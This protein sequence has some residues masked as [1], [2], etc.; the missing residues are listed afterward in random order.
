VKR[1]DPA[2]PPVDLS[3]EAVQNEVNR[4]LAS[5]KFARSKR[6]R[7]LL[8]FTV[9]QTLQGNADS[10][11]EYVI[12]TEV[13]NKPETYDPRRDS[14]V[15][16]LA[17]RLRLKLKEYYNDGGSEDPLV[18]EFPKG[19][20]VP[21]FQRREHLQ[22]ETEKKLKARNAYSRGKFLLLKLT[23]EALRESAGEFNDAAAADPSW[24]APQVGLATAY[25]LLGFLGFERPREVWPQ[26]ITAAE[27]ALRLDEM[28]SEPHI[29]LGMA[30]AFYD[31]RWR[32][33]DSHFMKAVERDPYSGA[34]PVWR[35][36]ASLL[37]MG[38]VAGARVEIERGRDLAPAPF[39]KEAEVLALY[40]AE[41]YE[42]VLQRTEDVAHV[43]PSL[44]WLP[45]LRSAALAASG[46]GDAA[47]NSLE[48]L[49]EKFPGSSRVAATLGQVYG[50][51]GR[52]AQANEVLAQMKRRREGGAWVP[53]FDFAVVHA[54]MGSPDEAFEALQESVKEKET[55]LVYLTVD[56]RLS[57]LRHSPKFA[58][59]VRRVVLT[60]IEGSSLAVE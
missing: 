16:V 51:A 40:F 38:R 35:A 28:S 31:W 1:Y 34:G 53:N 12:G 59:L 56:P 58:Q 15:R 32:D 13:L 6:L 41:Q 29:A 23:E 10:L 49:L 37:P 30:R 17:S 4:I 22:A 33:A 5:E 24:P 48:Q 19:K 21:R 39:V 52:T 27:A 26:V 18:I 46:R 3:P 55:W 47:I 9:N 44:D 25:S 11:K 14:L 45:W 57:S 2:S 50:L 8:R 20:Y 7:S 36:L 42:A 54:G 60:D 43:D